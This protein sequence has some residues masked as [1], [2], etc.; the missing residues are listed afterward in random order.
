MATADFYRNLEPFSRF[1][2]T[3]DDRHYRAVP[4]DWVVILTDVKGSTQAIEEG[5]Y[6]DVNTV[7][8]AGIV[9]VY[10]ALDSLDFPFVFGGDGATLLL[11]REEVPQVAVE[12]RALSRLAWE[13]FNLELRVGVVPV[14]KLRRE[15]KTIEVARY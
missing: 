11:D 14:R 2:E 6:K 9:A 5:R 1:E 7:G 15:G 8:A 3:A 10:N 12:L 4:D 13:N